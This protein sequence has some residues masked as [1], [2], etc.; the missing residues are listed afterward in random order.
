MYSKIVNA[1]DWLRRPGGYLYADRVVLGNVLGP[2]HGAG[3]STDEVN[4]VIPP[5][6]KA[7]PD[8]TECSLSVNDT[9]IQY[10]YDGLTFT[11]QVE[12]SSDLTAQEQVLQHIGELIKEKGLSKFSMIIPNKYKFATLLI[13]LKAAEQFK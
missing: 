4:F 2:V 5:E 8:T 6:S 3:L 1:D 11:V 7:Q 13:I 10:T 9:H 12:T